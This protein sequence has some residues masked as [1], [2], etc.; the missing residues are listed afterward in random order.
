MACQICSTSK[1]PAPNCGA[2]SSDAARS[3]RTSFGAV[4]TS[5][6]AE[7]VRDIEPWSGRLCTVWRSRSIRRHSNRPAITDRGCV[8]SGLLRA[9]DDSAGVLFELNVAVACADG[10]VPVVG[11]IVVWMIRCGHGR[12][13][14]DANDYAAFVLHAKHCFDTAKV[15]CSVRCRQALREMGSDLG[16]SRTA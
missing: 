7:A 15:L 5:D 3:R 9:S 2:A 8:P 16:L 4:V 1:K 14:G 10:R 12:A 13:D 11:G 6:R